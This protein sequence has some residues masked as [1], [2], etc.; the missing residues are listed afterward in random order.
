MNKLILEATDTTPKVVLDHLE[1]TFEIS[2]E[3]SPED[4]KLFYAALFAWIEQYKSYLYY[5]NDKGDIKKNLVFTF[6]LSYVSSSALKYT[7]NFLQHIEELKPLCDTV[8]IKW[9]YDKEDTDME[10]NGKEFS[11]MVK[12]PFVIEPAP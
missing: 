6:H 12:I 10:D 2:G 1:N 9:L 3:A 4:A 7:Y 8:T 5:L 11:T